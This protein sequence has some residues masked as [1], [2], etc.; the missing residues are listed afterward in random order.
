MN[1][2]KSLVTHTALVVALSLSLAACGNKGPLFL[3]SNPP[4]MEAD[5]PS[6]PLDDATVPA[7]VPADA[8]VDDANGTDPETPPPASDDDGNDRAHR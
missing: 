7:D 3:P 5:E 4:P 6:T 2:K 8:P 1:P